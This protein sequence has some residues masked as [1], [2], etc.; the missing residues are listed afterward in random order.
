MGEQG[1]FLVVGKIHDGVQ[2]KLMVALLVPPWLHR[3]LKEPACHRQQKNTP[4]KHK[5]QGQPWEMDRPSTQCCLRETL[6]LT[7]A[8]FP[9]SPCT[10]APYPSTGTA[11]EYVYNFG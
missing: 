4:A 8:P 5:G 2:K 6:F 7:G 9:L 11:R 10:G 3:M 1:F